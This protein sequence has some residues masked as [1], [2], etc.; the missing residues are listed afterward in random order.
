MT[1]GQLRWIAELVGPAGCLEGLGVFGLAE[2]EKQRVAHGPIVRLH[3]DN[4]LAKLRTALPAYADSGAGD[5]GQDAVTRRVDEEFGMHRVLNL[6]RQLPGRDRGE[7]S[8]FH[9]PPVAGGVQEQRQVRTE[10][11]LPVEDTVPDGIGQPRVAPIVIEMDSLENA[12][13]GDINAAVMLHADD[14]HPQLRTGVAAQHRPVVDQDRFRSAAHRPARPPPT[15][16]TSAWCSHC[17]NP[18]NFCSTL[19]MVCFFDIKF[20]R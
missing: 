7:T 3:R 5:R 2:L 15:T 13:F 8:L 10:C 19:N 12:G 20:G 11:R 18:F 1:V 14:P 17:S 6:A 16:Q 9:P 4:A